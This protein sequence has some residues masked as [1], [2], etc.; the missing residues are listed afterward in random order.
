MP[1]L[2][3]ADVSSGNLL[4]DS[5]G[6][7]VLS[8]FGLS[9]PAGGG[10]VAGVGGGGATAQPTDP[11]AAHPTNPPAS[12]RGAAR[13]YAW[14]YAAPEL[15]RPGTDGPT[16]ATDVWAAGVVLLELLTGGRA[17]G[18]R[19]GGVG[20]AAGAMGGNP[21]VP[22]TTPHATLAARLAPVL[23]DL[24]VLAASLAAVW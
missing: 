13:A 4:I 16:P 8:D 10:G 9:R 14:G 23:A 20:G 17:A 15:G 21:T 7:G 2:V 22:A 19:G 5:G 18:G 1:P 11:P 6:E 12:P 24:G 3:H